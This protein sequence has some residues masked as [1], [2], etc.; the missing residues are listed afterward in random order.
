MRCY[1]LDRS[2]LSEK[3]EDFQI[4]VKIFSGRQLPGNNIKPVV[5]VKAG[6]AQA[7]NTRIRKGSSPIWNEVHYTAICYILVSQTLVRD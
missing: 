2:I 5:Q 7:K 4:R 3:P 1:R 6:K